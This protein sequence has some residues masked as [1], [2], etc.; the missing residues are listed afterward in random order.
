MLFLLLAHVVSRPGRPTLLLVSSYFGTED[1]KQETYTGREQ[2]HG[3]WILQFLV[4]GLFDRGR[5]KSRYRGPG[6]DA[7]EDED[8]DAEAKRL[9][10]SLCGAQEDEQPA[11][12]DDVPSTASKIKKAAR[13]KVDFDWDV[14]PAAFPDTPLHAAVTAM[15][16]EYAML[17]GRITR[18]VGGAA[19]APMTLSEGVS[20]A[21]QAQDLFMGYVTP[22][23]GHVRTTKI[24]RVLCH[25]LYSIKYHGNIMNASTSMIEQEHKADKRHYI[26]T[27]KRSG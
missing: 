10:E 8:G 15:F 12:D 2:R 9:L 25:V 19:G 18:R 4:A 24:H 22:I 7:S 14:Y 5:A 27:N 1:E 23:L 20:I 13:P 21:Q 26:R 6:S 16:A 17:V 3:V 11:H